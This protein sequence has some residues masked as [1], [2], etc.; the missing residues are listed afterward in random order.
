ME[1]EADTHTIHGTAPNQGSTRHLRARNCY[2][3]VNVPPVTL[4]PPTTCR[5]CR[6]KLFHNETT[7]LCCKGGLVDVPDIPVPPELLELFSAQTTEGRNFRQNI[8]SY[9]HVFSFTSMGVTF[10]ENMPAFNQGI[11]TFR[12]HGAIY[13]RI[14]SLLPEYGTRPRFLQMFIY[15][16]EHE[17][18]NR[19]NESPDLNLQTIEKISNILDAVNPFV[20][21]LRQLA[22]HSDL[23]Q[24]R[25]LIKE[26]P[27][28]E[29]QYSLPTA[30]QVA[31]IL[32]GADDFLEANDRD[33]I[34]STYSG[35]LLPVKEYSGYY[36]PLQYPLLFPHG[37]YGWRGDELLDRADRTSCCD[38]TT[39]VNYR[40]H[41]SDVR[42][43]LY[44]GLQD[45]LQSGENDAG[46]NVGRRTILPSSFVGSPRDMFQRYQDAMAVVRNFGR[47]DI[48]LTMTC[49]PSWPEITNE[50]HPGQ[51]AQDR[52]DLVSRIFHAKLQCLTDDIFHKGVLGRVI[53]HVHVVEFQKRG[54]P[55][56]HMLFIFREQDKLTTP[57]D[58]DCVV[59]AEIPIQAEEPELYNA[60]LRHML[61][62]PCGR[63]RP[64]AQCMKNNVCKKGFPKPFMTATTHG[65]D[66]YPLYRRRDDNRAIPLGRDGDFMADNGW[67]VPYNPWL[68]LKYD[69]HINVE[70]CSSIKSIKYLYKYVY[71]GPDW[72]AF[73]VC[74]GP[75]YD[76]V[77]KY[78]DGRWICAPE[79]SWK[80]FKFHM[81]Q[82]FPS[83]VRLQIHLPDQHQ[84]QF[85]NSESI[86]DVLANERNSRTMLTEFFKTYNNGLENVPY[87]YVDFAKQYRW[88]TPS[89][90]WIRRV[91]NRSVVARMY[92]VSPTEGERFYLRLLLNHIP[93]PTSFNY[94]YTVQ[95]IRYTTFKEAAEK[96][97][98]LEEDNSVRECLA[99]ARNFRMPAALRRLFATILLYC[100]PTGVRILWDENHAAMSED[101]GSTS[102]ANSDFLI[103]RLLCEL[104]NI[105]EQYNKSTKDFDLP[106]LSD[107][108]Q[109]SADL[110]GLIDNELSIP[111]STV[112]LDSTS[113]LNN[114]QQTAYNTICT[115]IREG[116]G[117]IFFVDGPGGTGKTFLYR[118][119]LA[120]F[121][122]EGRIVIATATSGIAANLLP[123]GCTAH[124]RFKIPIKLENVL[125]CGFTKQSDL[126]KLVELS[127]AIIWDEAPMA[128]RK[129]FELLD[130]T[131]QD[132]LEIKKPFGGKV[133]IMGGDF[134]QVTP[135]VVNGTRLEIIRSSI[136]ESYLWSGVRL[137]KLKENMR[138]RH[139]N[140]FAEFLLRVGDG[141]EPTI[142]NDMIRLLDKIV[143]PWAGEQSVDDLINFVFPNIQSYDVHNTEA[144]YMETR[145]LIT[146][147]NEDVNKLNEKC[148]EMFPGDETTYYS[149][150]TVSD[151]NHNLYL[152][153]F[154]NSIN[155]GNL[156]THKLTLKRG[157]PIMLLR[158]IDPKIGLCNGTRLICRRFGRNIIEATI[159]VGHFK[160]QRVFIPRIPLKTAEDY[161]MP[162]EL[163][164]KQFPIRLSFALTIN[165]SQGQTIGKVGIYLP[166]HVFSHGQLYVA[167][168]RGV[169][170]QSTRVLVKNSAIEGQEGVYTR[171][172]VFREI[173]NRVNSTSLEAPI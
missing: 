148:L 83:V 117:G 4:S 171:N 46:N 9:N 97:G 13:H 48:F 162:F 56:A 82:T 34:V 152:P 8:R 10:D 119:I 110:P 72:V 85:R 136:V 6:A 79:A 116:N 94:L 65:L 71:K 130:R 151:D 165:K 170:A 141:E 101:Y 108:I 126:R 113:L 123:G 139:D 32:V 147:L 112:D 45:C 133:V 73:E 164:R 120:T 38:Y 128:N 50:L 59:R 14:G 18:E 49:N 1:L 111:I 104:N 138:A 5:H 100:Q 95:G 172:V 62:G 90:K 3:A 86:S 29:R 47:P 61:H 124:S 161:K 153:E 102:T 63:L 87:L 51:T 169:S 80:L 131:L 159:L 156:P 7:T 21:T 115:C 64:N 84:V 163:T 157:C 17:L 75:N 114:G 109:Y 36:D 173:F 31:A 41:Q 150:D 19:L 16:T 37:S 60:V 22:R 145:T 103:N 30:S 93:A 158:N 74:P 88:L 2:P 27:S 58:Y 125:T 118:S 105:F 144:E 132:V 91:R 33:I 98:L 140:E 129:T 160:G 134:R 137:L 42:A 167:L 25:L 168:S 54:L 143:M 40:S 44:K 99:E 70:I 24:C 67:V 122:N 15:D 107:N 166:N 43:E 26:K 96:Q 106:R 52:P 57:E 121:R 12:A 53:A 23:H 142:E 66:S 20:Q 55:H 154:L 127:A 77:S 92:A 89:R 81:Y 149:F 69:C 155:P 78:V 135:V 28:V 68:L 35:D 76:E 11:Y 39:P 146:P